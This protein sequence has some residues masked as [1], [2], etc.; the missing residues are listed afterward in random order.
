[1]DTVSFRIIG[2]AQQQRLGADRRV[3]DVMR[4]TFESLPSGTVATEDVP[5]TRYNPGTVGVLLQER[6]AT[7]ESVHAL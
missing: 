3:E 4:I 7:I 5:L 6:A 2:Q 1:M